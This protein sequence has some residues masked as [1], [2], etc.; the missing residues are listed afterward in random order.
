[1]LF[2]LLPLADEEDGSR[3]PVL[4]R[5]ASSR[6]DVRYLRRFRRAAMPGRTFFA[7]CPFS[8]WL[9][10]WKMMVEPSWYLALRRREGRAT[11]LTFTILGLSHGF[12][13]TTALFLAT[14]AIVGG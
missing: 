3:A 11:R 12:F 9:I 1:M 14:D 5:S 8:I 10:P 4:L 2:I 13:L 7:S 6:L